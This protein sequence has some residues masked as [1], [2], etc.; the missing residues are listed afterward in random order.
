MQIYPFKATI[1]LMKSSFGARGRKV[2]A[3]WPFNKVT[4]AQQSLDN[5]GGRG[6]LR[7]GDR[8]HHTEKPRKS[9]R[10][11]VEIVNSCLQSVGFL[12]LA[13][14]GLGPA[15]KQCSA[16]AGG[17]N[18]KVTVT[19]GRTGVVVPCKEGW[20]VRDL[21]H[22]ATQSAGMQCEGGVMDSV[23]YRTIVTVTT[24]AIT[25]L[26][27]AVMMLG[28]EGDFLVR[29]HHVEYCDGGILDPDD[30]L[31]DL[32]EDKDKRCISPPPTAK[33]LIL[34]ML[35][36]G[37]GRRSEGPLAVQ[38][39]RNKGSH[40][41]WCSFFGVRSASTRA[42]ESAR[43]GVRSLDDRTLVAVYEEQEAQQR[44][45]A[46]LG[47]GGGVPA[48]SGSRAGQPSPEPSDSELSCFQPIR[49]GEIEVNSSALKSRVRCR[50]VVQRE[51]ICTLLAPAWLS[52]SEHYAALVP[53]AVSSPMQGLFCSYRTDALLWPEGNVSLRRDPS[54]EA[55]N[56]LRH[57]RPCS[58]RAEWVGDV[59][60][61]GAKGRP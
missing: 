40:E 21:I 27:S 51:G 18:M 3:R 30:V 32:V 6:S 15:R 7:K 38:C 12:E 44:V 22:Q 31:A 53:S 19:F 50:S 20:T 58:A 2:K 54:A 59:A 61:S 24:I 42:G 5:S 11:L 29:T 17:L 33:A 36:V 41:S 55:G 16:S 14:D 23:S 25:V 4:A 52:H 39:V 43:M 45:P 48:N 28:L 57:P 37:S 56:D 1:S 26:I 34:S 9:Y 8:L 35:R 60:G 47:G 46:S 49:G 13:E 10:R